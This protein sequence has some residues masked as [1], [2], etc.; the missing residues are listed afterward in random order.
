MSLSLRMESISNY[1]DV[2]KLVNT[3]NYLAKVCRRIAGLI[4]LFL[5]IPFTAAI[6][7]L[8]YFKARSHCK[9]IS[10]IIQ[11]TY[12]DIPHM[13]EREKIETHLRFERA[14][15]E[16]FPNMQTIVHDIQ[17]HAKRFLVSKTLKM[18]KHTHDQLE[19]AESTLKKAAYPDLN[20]KLTEAEKKELFQRYQA[21]GSDFSDWEGDEYDSYI[22]QYLK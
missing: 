6:R 22:D 15:R 11:K 2:N 17:K 16:A 8:I 9:K 12:S 5:L 4:G 14:I 10:G 1:Q 20:R 21:S 19:K 7:I 3:G 13:S 18:I